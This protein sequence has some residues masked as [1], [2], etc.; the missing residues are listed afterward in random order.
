MTSPVRTQ[1]PLRAPRQAPSRPRSRRPES[2]HTPQ[3]APSRRPDLRVVAKPRVAAEPHTHRRTAMVLALAGTLVF[4]SLLA[5]AV[6]HSILVTGQDNLDRLDKTIVSEKADLQ[7]AKVSLA[8]AQSPQRIAEEAAERGMVPADYQTWLSP[9]SG[10]DAVVTG[11]TADAGGDDG[12][13]T[14]DPDS[15][16]TTT[17]DSTGGTPTDQVDGSVR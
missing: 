15:G 17:P 12:T 13:D 9:G 2:R 6:F 5:S 1:S 11:T 14:D 4:G 7:R 3:V 8:T 10:A 16:T